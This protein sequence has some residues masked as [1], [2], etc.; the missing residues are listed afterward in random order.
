[1]SRN[2]D[3]NNKKTQSLNAYVVFKDE[4][5]T[6]KALKMTG[7]EYKGQHIRVTMA[8]LN[9]NQQDSKHVLFVGNL[10]YSKRL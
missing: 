7:Q 4:N 9:D 2:D 10:K 1:M 3:D 8:D 6:T 5:S